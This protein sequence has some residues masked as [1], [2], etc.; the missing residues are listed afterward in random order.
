MKKQINFKGQHFTRVFYETRA[1]ILEPGVRR[2]VNV[3]SGGSTKSWSLAQIALFMLMSWRKDYDGLICRKVATTLKK[4]VVPLMVDQ[5]IR[6]YGLTN[7]FEYNKTDKELTNVV[8][9]RKIYF[10][11]M[12]DP[13]KIKSIP[14][15]GWFWAEE[16]TEFDAADL[17]QLTVRLRGVVKPIELY[18]YNPIFELHELCQDYQINFNQSER[19]GVRVIHSTYLDNPWIVGP[20]L[21]DQS[22]FDEM[23]H[24][25]KTDPYYYTV[26]YLGLPGVINS[27]GEFY[28]AFSLNE[29]VIP[30]VA[31]DT[32]EPLHLTFDEN[33]IPF[34]TCNVIQGSGDYTKQIDEIHIDTRGRLVDDADKTSVLDRTINEFVRRYPP[35]RTQSKVYI[36]GDPT[37]RKRDVKLDWGA[38]LY[39]IIKAKL[40]AAGYRVELRVAESAPP[41]NVVG[42]WENENVFGKN[43]APFFFICS[44][45]QSTINDY[46]YVKSA[47]DGA[48]QK[49]RLKDKVS[50]LT[51]EPFGHPSD[52]NDYFLV[53]YFRDNFNAW[54]NS[55]SGKRRS[56]GSGATKRF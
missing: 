39:S 8:T 13:E 53:R 38:N 47:M 42:N 31:W 33:V 21:R 44:N 7:E 48:K 52:A 16:T 24:F 46:I 29:H 56:V 34:F 50:G 27:G 14:N 35:D 26:Y 20:I 19:P 25:K 4:S 30:P 23:E 5:L 49:I 40:T 3:G 43:V 36:Y 51:Y 28:R 32:G 22:F 9:G 10:A 15:L 17:K 18:S 41:P 12:D 1:A 45:C 55:S 54:K 2:I 6:K 11:G 37:S